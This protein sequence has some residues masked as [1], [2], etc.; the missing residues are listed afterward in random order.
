M[1][2]LP[3]NLLLT[4]PPSCGKTPVVGPASRFWRYW[5]RNWGGGIFKCSWKWDAACSC[6]MPAAGSKRDGKAF[7]NDGPTGR[8][9]HGRRCG[10]VPL[11]RRWYM[12]G[13]APALA[14]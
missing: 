7:G 6:D 9:A 10:C 1:D 3:K 14:H 8:A 12:R 2:R 4:E 5:S 11:R 13:Y